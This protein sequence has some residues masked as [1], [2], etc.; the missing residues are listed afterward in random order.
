MPLHSRRDN[1]RC[2]TGSPLHTKKNDVLAA[3]PEEL[4]TAVAAG[5]PR[6]ERERE[7]ER[8]RAWTNTIVQDVYV[9]M[10]HGYG[11]QGVCEQL[12]TLPSKVGLGDTQRTSHVTGGTSMIGSFLQKCPCCIA[13]RAR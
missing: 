12:R 1:Y 3:K 6:R 13:R 5:R 9:G 8:E 4:D 7:R 10:N 2:M 11:R